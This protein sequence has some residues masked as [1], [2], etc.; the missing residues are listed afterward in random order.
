MRMF[1]SRDNFSLEGRA[2]LWYIRDMKALAGK[3]INSMQVRS[4]PFYACES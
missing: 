3:F 4:G 2:W 1:G